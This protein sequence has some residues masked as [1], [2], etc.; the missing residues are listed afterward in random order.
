MGVEVLEVE[1]SG[2]MGRMSLSVELIWKWF[3]DR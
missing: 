1:G 2:G 3:Q